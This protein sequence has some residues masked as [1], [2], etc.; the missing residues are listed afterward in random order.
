MTAKLHIDLKQGLID[1]EG[2]PALVE[3]IYNDFKDRLS[4][5]IAEAGEAGASETGAKQKRRS[6]PRKRTDS[7][8]GSSIDPD[9]PRVLDL[10]LS[11]LPGFYARYKPKGHAEK[12]LIFAAFLVDEMKIN[13]PNT[14][15]F[16]S[17]YR[18]IDEKSPNAFAQAFRDA[19]NRQ[20]YLAYNSPSE[21]SITHKGRN[22]LLHSVEKADDE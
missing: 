4:Q 13:D 16:Y 3:K 21:I 17:C 1:I 12:L 7:D 11:G 14:D 2:D 20:G 19:A 15:H 5:P 6:S 22:H 10:E 8:D 9:N 18:F